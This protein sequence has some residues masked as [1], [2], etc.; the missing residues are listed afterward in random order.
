MHTLLEEAAHQL[1]QAEAVVIHTGAGMGR[2]AGLADYRGDD[3]G[4]WGGLEAKTGKS[5]F[6]LVTPKNFKE[7]PQFAWQFFG[8]RL[9]EF[10]EKPPHEG[11]FLLKKWIEK[12]GWDYFI[13]TS[14][15]DRHFQQAGFPEERIREVHGSL[16]HFQAE[17][18]EQYPEVWGNTIPP[19][20]LLTDAQQGI[21]P[22]TPDGKQPAR[23][24]VYMFRDFTYVASR[25]K[26]Q[27]ENY[28]T[29]LEKNKTKKIVVFEIGSGPHVQT[30][31][32]KTRELRKLGAFV[33]RIN[34]K[35]FKIKTPHIGLSLGALEALQALDVLLCR[36]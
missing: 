17:D 5:I 1:L 18:P 34:P 6:E 28:L 16:S 7:N 27:K 10:Q 35:D 24:N 32:I 9:A 31:R 4:Q 36:K 26:A 29:F 12:F 19:K 15:I 3:G 23:P 11:Y 22:K 25:S 8:E 21:F 33:I 20:Q 14:N 13:Q 2:D 30:I